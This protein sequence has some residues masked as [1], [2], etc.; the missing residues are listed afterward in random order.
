GSLGRLEELAVRLAAIRGTE[1]P[2]GLRAAVVLAAADHGVA[3]RGVSAY[4]QEVTRQMLAN[5]EAGGAAICVL[6]RQAGAELRVHDRGVGR[7]TADLAEGP[8][9]TLAEAERELAAGREAV[10][11]LA[12]E[13]FGI[14]ALGEMGI[15]N[16][17][18]AAA[19]ASALLPADAETT[20]GRGT[21]L[22]DEGL[23][24]KVETVRRALAVNAAALGDPPAALAALGG[25]EIAFLAGVALE[26]AERGVVVLLDGFITG[27]AALAA[28]RIA[29]GTRESMVAA[30]VSPE[31]GHRP[32]LEA[33]ELRPLLDLGLR[34]GEGSGAALALP[35]L[36][37]ALAI[38]DGMATF[39]SAGVTDARR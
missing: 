22:D 9:M 14:A 34:L 16:T 32:V 17:T 23:A 21:G 35:L 27:A 37:A 24:R 12:A 1:T 4:P 19:L 3:A 28:E 2:G 36:H 25:F 20:C 6:A 29:P 10:A 5:F 31:P 33:L 30:H 7:P 26:A 8:A 15:G 18:S 13:G 38:L 39:D 11:A